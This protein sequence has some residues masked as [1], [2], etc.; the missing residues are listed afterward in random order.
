MTNTRGFT[1]VELLVAVGII[2]VLAS[3]SIVSINSVRA[4][5][6]DA[7]RVAD[8]KTLQNALETYASDNSGQYPAAEDTPQTLGSAGFTVL[9]N[10]GPGFAD[11]CAAGVTVYMGRVN[12]DP[13][14]NS[15][16][17]QGIDDSDGS[18]CTDAGNDCTSYKITFILEGATGSFTKSG[19]DAQRTYTATPAGIE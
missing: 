10:T 1:L 16:T 4:K 2:G 9:C 18:Q 8:V 11:T 15:I 5:A 3:V 14:T 17:Y 13:G 19:T 6:R 12:P 7:K